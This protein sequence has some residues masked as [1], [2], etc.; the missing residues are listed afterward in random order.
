MYS[1][2]GL[3]KPYF[4]FSRLP[5]SPVLCMEDTDLPLGN[6]SSCGETV[7]SATS[8]II[9]VEPCLLQHWGRFFTLNVNILCFLSCKLQMT[10]AILKWPKR[11]W[12]STFF[13]FPSSVLQRPYNTISFRLMTSVEKNKNNKRKKM[14]WMVADDAL[15]SWH[16]VR[17]NQQD[18]LALQIKRLLARIC[19][20]PSVSIF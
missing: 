17:V 8:F 20:R 6:K 2:T 18:W 19:V 1:L 15:S 11:F 13:G 10:A 14:C 4:V 3:E 12:C 16:P 7:T 9:K 5:W